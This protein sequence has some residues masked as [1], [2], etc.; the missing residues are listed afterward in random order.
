MKKL[1][2][3]FLEK[4]EMIYNSQELG[5]IEEGFSNPNPTVFRVNTLKNDF[6]AVQNLL[7]YG[8]E[9]EKIDFLENAYK[10][11]KTGKLK[12][13]D[14]KAFKKWYIYLQ[15]I[16]SQIPVELVSLPLQGGDLEGVNFKV[17]DLTAAPGWK[18]TQMSARM[19]NSWTIIANEKSPIRLEK[20]KYTVN[21]QEANNVEIVKFDANNLKNNFEEWFFDVIIADLPCSAEWRINL[22]KEKSYKYLEKQWINKRN[23][24]AQQAILKNTV[25][26]LKS[27][28][29][30]I[31]S[32][33]TLD[34]IENEGI[35]NYLLF[36][37]P[38]LELVDI[39]E[40][41]NRKWLKEISKSWILKY[42]KQVYKPEV[43]KSSSVRTSFNSVKLFE[44]LVAVVPTSEATP[45]LKPFTP[46]I[47]QEPS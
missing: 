37:F 46:N 22:Q 18:T 44:K 20:L 36:E 2:K 1:D 9:V 42:K 23:Y 35:V 8:F 13:S 28:G 6:D 30:L 5:I 43:A 31:Y 10:I 19:N 32:T 11:T 15:G 14:L 39:S 21:K 3:S 41:F 17:L 25:N 29:Q 4:L 33:C 45:V 27:W 47:T 38:E 24:K 26:L 40:Y 12:L 34:P 7:D 16:T